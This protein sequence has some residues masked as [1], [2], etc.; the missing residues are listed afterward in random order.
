VS[1]IERIGNLLLIS[2]LAEPSGSAT[3]I[4]DFAEKNKAQA[5]KD[6]YMKDLPPA[7]SARFHFPPGRQCRQPFSSGRRK[8]SSPNKNN[9][10]R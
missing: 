3:I 10:R 2:V 4:Q 6:T 5:Q 8:Q 7:G 9:S 1:K